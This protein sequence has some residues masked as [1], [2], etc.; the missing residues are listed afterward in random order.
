MSL[1][2]L[3]KETKALVERCFKRIG[4]ILSSPDAIDLCEEKSRFNSV[5]LNYS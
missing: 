2:M 4:E 5:I 3:R 1:K